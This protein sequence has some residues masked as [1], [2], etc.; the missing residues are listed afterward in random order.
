[1]SR[2]DGSGRSAELVGVAQ[3]IARVL[4]KHG[5]RHQSVVSRMR[6]PRIVQGGSRTPTRPRRQV[7]YQLHPWFGHDVIIHAAIDKPDGAV[8]RCALE[9]SEVGRWLEI[10]AWMFDRATCA[11]DVQHSTDPFI[12]LEVL[13]RLSAL[14]SQALK[15]DTASSNARLR[16]AYGISHD[17]NRGDTHGTEDNGVCDRDAEQAGRQTTADGSI[18]E[19]VSGRR[20]QLARPPQRRARGAG[21]PDGAAD[22]GARP[23]DGDAENR[24]GRP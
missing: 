19:P 3:P 16:D 5:G 9:G 17:R 18:R 14:L 1:M 22:P 23:D 10:P 15:S 2:F 12:S 21:Q 7:L 11:A 8:F 24:E 6:S 4:V 13:G 20:T